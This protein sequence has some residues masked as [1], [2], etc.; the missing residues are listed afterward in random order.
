MDVLCFPWEFLD[1]TNKLAPPSGYNR[2]QWNDE[3]LQE[4]A[5]WA[6]RLGERTDLQPL[7]PD[8]PVS[9]NRLEGFGILMLIRRNVTLN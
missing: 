4:K 2:D 7:R 3:T 9:A 5:K 1:D 8:P 6:A